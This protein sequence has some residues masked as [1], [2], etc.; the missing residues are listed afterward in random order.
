VF[1]KENICLFG[2]EETRENAFRFGISHFK[3]ETTET[4]LPFLSSVFQI[5]R[6]NS[7]ADYLL[8]INADIIL[9]GDF[10]RAAGAAERAFKN[11]FFMIGRRTNLDVANPINFSED[12]ME[13]KL[14]KLAGEKGVLAPMTAIDYFLF[15]KT[16]FRDIPPLR[17]GRAGFDN[18][19]IY[20]AKKYE[21]IAVIDGTAEILAIH[22]NHDYRHVSGGQQ[23]VFSGADAEENIKLG[24]GRK[25]LFFMTECDYKIVDDNILKNH[26]WKYYASKRYLLEVLPALYPVFYPLI[27]LRKMIVET[28][29]KLKK[30]FTSK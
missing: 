16:V 6:K 7:D 23:T 2:D 18:I 19:L 15:P 20:W 27:P 21:K 30:Q 10:A 24:G 4:G 5:A 3:S 1:G 28:K 26:G 9:F 8:Y 29:K 22:Q 25:N 17:V 11:K 12:G 13:E 14:R